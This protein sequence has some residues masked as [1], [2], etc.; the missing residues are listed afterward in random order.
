[1]GRGLSGKAV[2][3]EPLWTRTGLNALRQAYIQRS[4]AL[5]Y[6]CKQRCRFSAIPPLNHSTLFIKKAAAKGRSFFPILQPMLIIFP[7]PLFRRFLFA[8]CTCLLLAPQGSPCSSRFARCLFA[9]RCRPCCKQHKAL[10]QRR[11]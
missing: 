10:W 1:M 2:Y 11:Y 6:C 8:L 4:F 9:L 3:D 5:I 7:A